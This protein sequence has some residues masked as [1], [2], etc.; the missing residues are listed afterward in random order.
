MLPNYL[1][2]DFNENGVVDGMDLIA[3]SMNLG[4]AAS[5]T[6]SQGD[7]DVD[8]DVDGADFLIWQRQRGFPSSETAN[9]LSV[10]E[11]DG[12]LSLAIG[13]VVMC[14]SRTKAG[15]RRRIESTPD[16]LRLHV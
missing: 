3:L 7:A 12:G 2:A 1:E 10:P 11:S 13:L 5:A 8:S 15:S 4:S 16:R 14:V 6:K 9:L